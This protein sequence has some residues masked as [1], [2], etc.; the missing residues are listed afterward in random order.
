MEST[1]SMIEKNL[2]GRIEF[3]EVC[4]DLQEQFDKFDKTAANLSNNMN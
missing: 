1:I 2:I 4:G 3:E